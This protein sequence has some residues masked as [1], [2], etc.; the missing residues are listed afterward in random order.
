MIK[1]ATESSVSPKCNVQ[2]PCKPTSVPVSH[3]KK[4][5]ANAH[6]KK[7]L[8]IPGLLLGHRCYRRYI[9]KQ[10]NFRHVKNLSKFSGYIRVKK[11]MFVLTT[12]SK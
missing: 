5:G 3:G 1:V 2:L 11:N 9:P 8:S 10:N 7:T 4:I 6:K 12:C